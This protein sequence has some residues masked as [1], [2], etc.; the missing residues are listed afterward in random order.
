LR[1][2]SITQPLPH[3]AIDILFGDP[4]TLM[5]VGTA[6]MSE[7]GKLDN[8]T[9][10]EKLFGI[11]LPVS[12]IAEIKLQALIL[13]ISATAFL[14]AAM[15]AKLKLLGKPEIAEK[16]VKAKTGRKQRGRPSVQG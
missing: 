5:I 6:S 10:D 3:L 14:A 15:A 13:G 9:E 11:K 8:Q 1:A 4:S 16:L 2:N 7:E 12:V